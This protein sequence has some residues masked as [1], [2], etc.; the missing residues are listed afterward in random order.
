MTYGQIPF[1]KSEHSNES[2]INRFPWSWFGLIVCLYGFWTGLAYAY[3][4]IFPGNNFFK[5]A[6]HMFN[7]QSISWLLFLLIPI[8]SIVCDITGKLFSNMYFPMQTQIHMEI[9]KEI[10][11]GKGEEDCKN[12]DV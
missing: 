12:H 9:E 8:A 1:K 11:K 3:S 5:I 7:M 6:Y 10:L 2:W 4:S